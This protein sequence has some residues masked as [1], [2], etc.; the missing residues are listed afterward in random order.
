M[1]EQPCVRGQ[2]PSPARVR[3][4]TSPT[5]SAAAC[6]RAKGTWSWGRWRGPSQ[7]G[8]CPPEPLP[9]PAVQ[10]QRDRVHFPELHQRHPRRDGVV[11]AAGHQHLL[12]GAHAQAGGDELPRRA[13]DPGLP[14]RVRALQLQVSAARPPN[15][16][17]CPVTAW[18]G[19]EP[20]RCP[21]PRGLRSHFLEAEP[22]T[23]MWGGSMT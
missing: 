23:G 4:N 8:L 13:A 9:A 6:P 1:T 22:E 18:C 11:P 10:P 12:A 2:R 21:V 15:T 20:A 7:P 17:P 5:G 16:P 3:V 19:H 14:V